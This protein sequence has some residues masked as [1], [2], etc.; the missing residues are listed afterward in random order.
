[1]INVFTL[2]AYLNVFTL[3]KVSGGDQGEQDQNKLKIRCWTR[4]NINW[5]YKMRNRRKL[6]G[7]N[8]KTPTIG[9]RLETLRLS[10][11]EAYRRV[12]LNMAY[13]TT[14]E[15]YNP[16][17]SEDENM[18]AIE[19]NEKRGRDMLNRQISDKEWNRLIH[20][21]ESYQGDKS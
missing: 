10:D 9:D 11:Y 5:R 15:T 4:T 20:K 17:K 18:E 2:C 16:N 6:N 7:N 19:R 3:H 12:V 8:Q 21:S 14:I 13:D 1:M